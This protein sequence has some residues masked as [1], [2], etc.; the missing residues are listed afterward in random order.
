MY[1]FR[2]QNRELNDIRFEFSVNRD[3]SHGV[4]S[5]LVA[6]GLVDGKDLV[7]IAANLDKITQFP[8]QGQ[9]L[10]FALVSIWIFFIIIINCD[11][12]YS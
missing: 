9:N 8:E 4:A 12:G 7:V 2:N 10:T 11:L 6:A 1:N 3:T 5:E